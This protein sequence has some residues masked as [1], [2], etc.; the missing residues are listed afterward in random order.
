MEIPEAALAG[1]PADIMAKLPV[2]QGDNKTRIIPLHEKTVLG[3]MLKLVQNENTRKLI[4]FAHSNIN[5]E[6][7]VPIIDQLV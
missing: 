7:N 6:N 3:P 2:K 4:D 1:I 5:K